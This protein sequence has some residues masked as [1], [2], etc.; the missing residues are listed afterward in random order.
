MKSSFKIFCLILLSMFLLGSISVYANE[1]V[2]FGRHST[3][4]TWFLEE[5]KKNYDTQTAGDWVLFY[6]GEPSQEAGE[7][8]TVTAS[9]SYSHTYSGSFGM[10]AIKQNVQAQLGYSFGVTETFGV[11]KSS[12]QLK[13]GEYILAYYKR[14]YK[15][16]K[17]ISQKY[18]YDTKLITDIY[19]PTGIYA[20][21]ICKEAIQPK[22]KLE[23][24]QVNSYRTMNNNSD[25]LVKIE[26]YEYID[27]EYILVDEE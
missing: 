19:S 25:T 21:A 4:Y 20:T 16:S 17:S 24:H 6:E 3:G 18:Y 8:D 13:K 23:Y 2:P 26:V 14:N 15:L 10:S 9:T 12:R 1:V 5:I 27:G 22:L 7:V 11:S